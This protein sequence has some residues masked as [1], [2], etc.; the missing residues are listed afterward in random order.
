MEQHFFEIKQSNSGEVLIPLS[1]T[2]SG[3]GEGYLRGMAVSGALAR[4]TER[5]LTKLGITVQLRPA[6][7]TLDLFRPARNVETRVRTEVVRQGRRLVLIDAF[8]EQQERIVARSATLFLNPTVSPQSAVWNEIQ[9]PE[10]PPFDLLP[11]ENDERIYYEEGRGWGRSSEAE[12]GTYRHQSWH[13]P[14]RI[15]RGEEPTSFQM[16]ASICDV[17]N[18]VSNWGDNG[19]EFIN[20][21]V[22]L[23]LARVPVGPHMGLSATGRI[24]YDGLSN[25]SAVLYDRDGVFGMSLV[26]GLANPEARVDPRTRK[27]M[28]RESL[29]NVGS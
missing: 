15:V 11:D 10:E 4:A 16:A 19:L 23:T 20:G 13:F 26:T 27:A 21:D 9:V 1:S 7:F 29:D 17:S 28:P 25:G 6:R 3:W 2:E 12:H 8:F 24:E 22:T 18:V 5:A 14:T